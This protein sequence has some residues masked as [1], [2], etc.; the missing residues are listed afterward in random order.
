MRTPLSTL[1]NARVFG[2][3]KKIQ[4]EEIVPTDW[5]K[6]M[7]TKWST[8][9]LLTA[10]RPHWSMQ[11]CESLWEN[12]G[13]S[14]GV[15]IPGKVHLC[16]AQGISLHTSG[17]GVHVW[18]ESL[19]R[20]YPSMTGLSHLKMAFMPEDWL[21]S[22][23]PILECWPFYKWCNVDNI[24]SILTLKRY[25]FLIWKIHYKRSC[26]QKLIKP[27]KCWTS[28]PSCLAHCDFVIIYEDTRLDQSCCLYN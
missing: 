26:T 27:S 18:D 5:E 6:W 9:L 21:R 19:L 8:W 22:L 15:P 1:S 16:P 14:N 17:L 25:F 24:L 3:E 4:E 20:R 10:V 11:I 23:S 12:T 7:K 2:V 13:Y 28:L